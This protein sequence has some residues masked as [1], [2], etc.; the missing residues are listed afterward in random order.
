MQCVERCQ[1]S[2]NSAHDQVW[3]WHLQS[4]RGQFNCQDD[5]FLNQTTG[6][7][8][9]GIWYSCVFFDTETRNYP[10]Y[11]KVNLKKTKYQ[12]HKYL[13]ANSPFC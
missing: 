5:S 11:A 6:F 9:Q 13:Y 8:D 12:I 3:Q 10:S 4:Q 2:G 1:W 7:E